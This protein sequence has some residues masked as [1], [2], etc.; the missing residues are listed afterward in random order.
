VPA[1]QNCGIGKRLVKHVEQ[2]ARRLGKKKLLVSTSNDDLPALAFYQRD[3]FQIFAVKP[4]VLAKKH[5]RVLAGIGGL[6]I[7][8]ELRMRIIL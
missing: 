4:N 2:E 3:G 6:P 7:R 1:Y 5:G 8:D